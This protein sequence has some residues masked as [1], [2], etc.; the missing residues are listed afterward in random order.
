M[1]AGLATTQHMASDCYQPE[2]HSPPRHRTKEEL[3]ERVLSA[4]RGVSLRDGDPFEKVLQLLFMCDVL[5]TC[6]HPGDTV[7]MAPASSLEGEM[8]ICHGRQAG[9]KEGPSRVWHIVCT[10]EMSK[11]TQTGG[12]QGHSAP[13]WHQETTCRHSR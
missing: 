11:N 3:S 1:V 13:R 2:K 6:Q 10:R 7:F 9:L 4:F 12:T 8:N 5:S